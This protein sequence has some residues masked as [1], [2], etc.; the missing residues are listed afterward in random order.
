MKPARNWELA[1]NCV[2]QLLMQGHQ[3]WEG[4][5][6]HLM[7]SGAK[8]GKRVFCVCISQHKIWMELTSLGNKKRK[9]N[10][11]LMGKSIGLPW[12]LRHLR[13]CLQCRRPGFDPWLGKMLWRRKWQPTPVFLPV[14]SHGWSSLSGYRNSWGC[15]QSDT[16]EQLHLFSLGDE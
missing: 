12:W 1:E 2:H 7:W 13:V 16:I 8:S 6:N 5:S 15:K 11:G 4:D 3:I 10:M 14:K 9:W